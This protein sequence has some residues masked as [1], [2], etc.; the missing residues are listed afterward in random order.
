MGQ[1]NTWEEVQGLP[2]A[3]VLR[4]LAAAAA[5]ARVLRY[6]GTWVLFLVGNLF[7]AGPIGALYSSTCNCS[8]PTAYVLQYCGIRSQVLLRGP[9]EFHRINRGP[10]L[11]KE[12]SSST[13]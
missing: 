8:S 11:G 6:L 3:W 7:P 10:A 2:D 12:C 5:A 4:F 9:V 13:W 1:S